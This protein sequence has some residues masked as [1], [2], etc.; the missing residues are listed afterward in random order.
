M[1]LTAVIAE[2][3]RLVRLENGPDSFTMPLIGVAELIIAEGKELLNT[4]K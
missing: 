4:L 2:A 3:G 1:M